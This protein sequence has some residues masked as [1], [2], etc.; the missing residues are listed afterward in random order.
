MMR[1]DIRSRPAIS[2]TIWIPTLWM[3]RIASRSL[4]YWLSGSGVGFEDGGAVSG[5][6][7]NGVSDVVF[8]LGMIFVGVI[9][10]VQ[11]RAPLG[12]IISDNPWLFLFFIYIAFSC[13]WAPE[14]FVA[15]KRFIRAVG[16]L[17]MALITLTEGA[18]LVG[19]FTVIRR[20]A[21]FYIPLSI[22]VCRYF[23][24]YG[25]TQS[26]S[27]DVADSWIGLSTHKNALCAFL[28][29][30]LMYFIWNMIRARRE[31]TPLV[32]LP[33]PKWLSLDLVYTAMAF[34]LLFHK[35]SRSSTAIVSLCVGLLVSFL[36]A[37]DKDKFWS[38]ILRLGAGYA[39]LQI[40]C[41]LLAGE[42]FSEVLLEIQGKHANLTGRTEYWPVLI[43]MGLKNPIL[44]TGY[45]AFWTQ[46]LMNHFLEISIWGYLPESHNGYIETFV[47]LGL[48]GLA[49]LL[50]NI[51]A[52]W[53][54]AWRM[55]S[56]DF[57]YGRIRLMFLSAIVIHN[58]AEAGFPR[59]NHT[60]WLIFLMVALYVPSAKPAPVIAEPESVI[61]DEDF[62][63][64]DQ[65]APVP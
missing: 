31:K 64:E 54:S 29:M 15:G 14:P 6:A 36:L 46:D 61:F 34:Y 16:D 12:R 30:A 35:P 38:W 13:V 40:L 7:G 65:P 8:L 10:L 39:V 20:T 18:P 48:I 53:K 45:G 59:E 32:K 5:A 42:S 9:A 51:V 25:R 63:A 55:L 37:R 44:G 56:T 57:E 22:L 17:I 24:Q 41:L 50:I 2:P 49:L 58:F 27:W 23:P 3:F 47:N 1:K 26:K 19:L 52:A 28:M 11:K 33:G 60:V 21:I 4:S 43:D 62:D